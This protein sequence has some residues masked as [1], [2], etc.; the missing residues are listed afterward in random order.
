MNFIYQYLRENDRSL[1]WLAKKVKMLPQTLGNKLRGLDDDQIK[2][3][4]SVAEWERIM[5]ITGLSC[6]ICANQTTEEDTW[7]R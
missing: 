4:L 7:N 2:H 1:T 5:Q 6:P 3:T